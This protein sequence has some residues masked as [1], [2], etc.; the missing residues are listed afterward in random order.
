VTTTSEPGRHPVVWTPEKA[1]RFWDWWTDGLP[2]KEYFA[3]RFGGAV[4]R[5]AHTVGK[6][7]PPA[8][9][10]DVGAGQGHLLE[11]LL[12]EGYECVGFEVSEESARAIQARLGGRPGFHGVHVGI[13]PTASASAGGFDAIFALEVIEHLL[14]DQVEPFFAEAAGALRPGGLLAGSTPNREALTA[15]HVLC[16]DCGAVFHP[17]Q[18]LQSWDAK[19]IE[20]TARRAGLE[21][22]AVVPTRLANARL[23]W[24]LGV[25]A[26]AFK[27]RLGLQHG[28]ARPN[29]L[30]ACRKPDDW[31]AS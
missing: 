1:A 15:A 7:T 20:D 8:M 14:D 2:E 9:V 30:F 25:T 22:V 10:A 6:L 13:G 18:H 3:E 27:R 21:P 17:V 23:E 16:P 29:L 11:A 12:E 19:R 4:L 28:V 31:V 5:F 24:L 26:A